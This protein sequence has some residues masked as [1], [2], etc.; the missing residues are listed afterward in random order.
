[1]KKRYFWA[2]GFDR[3]GGKTLLVRLRNKQERQFWLES[4]QG[5]WPHTWLSIHAAH[6]EVRRIQRRMAAG[7]QITFPVEIDCLCPMIDKAIAQAKEGL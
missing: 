4:H 5:L 1:M 3:T 2:L 7:E 6:P